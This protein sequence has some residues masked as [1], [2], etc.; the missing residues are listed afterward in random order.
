MKAGFILLLAIGAALPAQAQ[1]IQGS[2][3]TQLP[4][5]SVAFEH[6]FYSF[7]G[8]QFIYGHSGCTETFYVA[9]TF[10]VRGDSLLLYSADWPAYPPPPPAGPATVAARPASVH[11]LLIKKRRPNGLVLQDHQG[12][13]R[14]LEALTPAAHQALLADYARYRQPK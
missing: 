4:K 9:G 2:F 11:T 10:R 13:L 14:E 3:Q 8:T 1:A 5:G 12:W 6:D 7:T